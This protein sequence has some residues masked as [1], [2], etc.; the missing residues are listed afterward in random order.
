MYNRLNL[1][2][3]GNHELYDSVLRDS[4]LSMVVKEV[5]SDTITNHYGMVLYSATELKRAELLGPDGVSPLFLE[6]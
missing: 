1:P 6:K 2:S 5:S 3:L 4:G